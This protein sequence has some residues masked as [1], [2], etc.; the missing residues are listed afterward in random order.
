MEEIKELWE[1]LRSVENVEGLKEHEV[2]LCAWNDGVEDVLFGPLEVQLQRLPSS[3]NKEEFQILCQVSRALHRH[4]LN[5]LFPEAVADTHVGES[6][7]AETTRRRMVPPHVL[8]TCNGVVLV[9]RGSLLVQIVRAVRNWLRFYIQIYPAVQASR[10]DPLQLVV[11]SFQQ[12]EM[13]QLFLHLMEQ[14]KDQQLNMARHASQCLFYATYHPIPSADA[15]MQSIVDYLLKELELPKRILQLYVTTDSVGLALAL[16]QIIHNLLASAPAAAEAIRFVTITTTTASTSCPWVEAQEHEP[17]GY[18]SVWDEILEYCVGESEPPFPGDEGDYRAEL[19]G[20][21]LRSL[22]ALRIGATMT[23]TELRLVPKILGLH[24]ESDDARVVEC[25]RSLMTIFTEADTSIAS[26][27]VDSSMDFLLQILNLHV[28]AVVQTSRV[29]DAA[30]A[31]LTPVLLTFYR[32]CQGNAEF[33]TQTRQAV[34]PNDGG[35][36]SAASPPVNASGHQNMA[37]EDAPE[38]TLRWKLIRLLTWP[39]S[40]I[41][42]FAAEILWLVCG[43]NPQEFSRRV[44]MGNALPFLAAKGHAQLPPNVFR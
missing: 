29:D 44:G 31:A 23:P 40:H 16:T 39:Q 38:G 32:F 3:V 13:L 1:C 10:Q 35:H 34:F 15:H 26:V 12:Q 30:A 8:A 36:D 28:D 17:I 11:E 37:P 21:I 4:L 14:A 27:L 43:S 20:E 18:R 19:V 33:L 25:Q 2:R 24:N 7:K 22:F 9:Q 42:R 41:K 5:L 6:D